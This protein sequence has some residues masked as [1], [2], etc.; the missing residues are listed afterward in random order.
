MRRLIPGIIAAVAFAFAPTIALAASND[1]VAHFTHDTLTV[2]IGVAGIAAGLFLI[3][4][5]YVYITSTGKPDAVYEAKRTIRLALIGLAIVIG[6]AVLSSF[7]NTTFTSSTQGGLTPSLS[8]SPNQTQP[9][10][11]S[12][13]KLIQDSVV[14]FLR[15][16]IESAT[17]PVLDGIIGF[18]TN[19]PSLAGSSTVFNLWLVMVGITDSL[20]ALVIALLGFHV[21]SASTFGFEELTLKELFPR[22]GIAFV[23]AN[24]SIFLID[25]I[26]SLCQTLVQA[27]LAATG[28]LGHS[29]I[30]DA[31]N[32]STLLSGTTALI[33]LI[34]MAI[35]VVLA[36]ALLLFYIVR[37]MI[38]ALGVVLSPILALL[39]LIPRFNGFVESSITAYLVIIFSLF[40]H[41]V[42]LQLGA[43][44]IAI[45]GQTGSNPFISVLVGVALLSLLL[46]STSMTIRLALASQTSNAFRK[47]G[48]AIINTISSTAVRAGA[49]RVPRPGV[50]K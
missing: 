17:K 40:V 31:F 46:K 25:W 6:A 15:N 16:L 33:T 21:M 9:Q 10:P 1:M 45:P 12:I 29:W 50:A 19:T 32:P 4:G 7:L 3:R 37:L 13:S 34:M 24:T 5:G 47:T 20:F 36:I 48:K 42:I 11:F 23:V 8:V 28:G 26:V 43:A 38:L 18:L 49:T 39:W 27:V 2:L 14:D 30:V 35:F 41:V 44:F 22:I